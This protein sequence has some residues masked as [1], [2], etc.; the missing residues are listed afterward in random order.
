MDNGL[1]RQSALQTLAKPEQLD[2]FLKL[3]QPRAWLALGALLTILAA[4]IIWSIFGSLPTTVAGTGILISRGGV[5]NVATVGNGVVTEIADVKVGDPIHKSQLLGRIA[6]PE[7]AQQI[8]AAKVELKRLET[9]ESDIIKLIQTTKNA[10][11]N[12]F[13]SRKRTLEDI[14]HAKEEHLR[15][16]HTV[17]QSRAGLVKEGLITQQGY[18]ETQQAIYGE[19]NAINDVKNLLQQLGIEKLGNTDQHEERL[20]NLRSRI[21]QSQNQ[22]RDLEL[23]Y[24]LAAEIVSRH[25]GAVVEIMA[26]PGDTVVNGQAILSIELKTQNLEAVL[27]LPP[28]SNAK[29]LQPGMTARI[30]PV[31]YKKERY[32]YLLGKVS[33]VSKYPATLAGMMAMLH[34]ESLVQELS[35]YGPPIAVAVELQPDPHTQSGYTW[36]SEAGAVL[37]LSSGTMA[38][39]SFIIESKR[40]ISLLLPWLR[41]LTDL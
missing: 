8:Q 11:E 20:R 24:Q 3:T 7:M 17:K 21:V 41:E 18:E 4:I 27:Y 32:G 10:Q 40:P 15:S 26:M 19:E 38:T 28:L 5:F 1:F 22:L 30:S 6:Q 2:Q 39:G 36:S 34:N 37:D 9:E 13:H 14:I 12:S 29:R 35:K 31:T 16:L 25:D 23:H 33:S